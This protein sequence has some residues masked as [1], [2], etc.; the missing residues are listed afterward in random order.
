[1]SLD[2]GE[3]P[4]GKKAFRKTYNRELKRQADAE[5]FGEVI[6]PKPKRNMYNRVELTPELKEDIIQRVASGELL[7]SILADES[8]PSR[9][10]IF[11]EYERDP[12]FAADMKAARQVAADLLAEE[13]LEISDDARED[14]KPDGSINYELVARSKLRADNRK[15]L[16]SKFDPSRYA[17]KVQTDITSGGDK[18]EVKETSALE[19]A[20]QIAFAIEMAKRSQN[21]NS[22]E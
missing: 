19:S 17:D 16:A 4:L 10:S 11:R 7:K 22:G 2:V 9:F 13:V 12:E 8:M 1:M 20:R 18:I 6:P 21:G 3:A 5:V 15:W 14:Y